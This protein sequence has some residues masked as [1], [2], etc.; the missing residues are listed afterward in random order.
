MPHGEWRRKPGLA[1]VES[2][3]CQQQA[4][5]DLHSKPQWRPPPQT[6]NENDP[7]LTESTACYLKATQQSLIASHSKLFSVVHRIFQSVSS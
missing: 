3:T 1:P 4:H 7:V 6:Q 5:N 2:V